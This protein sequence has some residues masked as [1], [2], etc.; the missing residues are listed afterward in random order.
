MRVLVDTSVWSMA[1]RRKRTVDDPA[2]AELRELIKESRVQLIGPVRQEILSG[3]R[4]SAQFDRL[5]SSLRAFP[6]LELK[7]E[8][9]ERAAEMLNQCRSNGIQ[10][11]NTDFLICAVAERH[12]LSVLT[13]DADFALFAQHVPVRLHT[14][15]STEDKDG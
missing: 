6:D 11:S 14:P 3:L 2:V 10:G 9:Y 13:I 8:D 5:K 15:R 4:H 1:L 7:T 12:L